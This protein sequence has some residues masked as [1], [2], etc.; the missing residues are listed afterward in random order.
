MRGRVGY[1][2]C[3][4]IVFFQQRLQSP[5]R[6][7]EFESL[8]IGRSKHIHTLVILF[9]QTEIVLKDSTAIF[10]VTQSEKSSHFTLMT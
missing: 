1:K 10:F 8:K 3:M 7:R 4:S 9:R 2:V 6:V 5:K